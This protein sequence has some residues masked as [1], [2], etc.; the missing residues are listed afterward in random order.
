[1]KVAPILSQMKDLPDIFCPVLVHTGQHYDVQMSDVFFQELGLPEPDHHLGVGSGSHAQQTA[2]VLM[3][4][5]EVLSK[6]EPQVVVVVGDVNPTV[7]CAMDASKANIPVAH[8][9]AGL[10][11][12]DRR[13]P[14][15]I[16]RIVTDA[17]SDFLFTPS[18]DA[19][20]NLRGEGVSQNRIFRVGNVM[21]DSLRKMEPAADRSDVLERLG[22]REKEYALLTLHR[23]SN[24]DDREVLAGILDALDAI[25]REIQVIFTVHPRT[26]ARLEAFELQSRVV[27]M[28]GLTMTEPV[29]YLDSLKLQK[30]ARLVLTDS[31]G[32]QEETT[33]FGVPCLTLRENTER[34]VTIS[35]GTNTLVGVAP[36]AIV[37]AARA[38]L[39]GSVSKG[40]I[41]ELW[42][43]HTAERIVD[44]LQ[45]RLQRSG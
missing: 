12:R 4:F 32:L 8:V 5:E 16:N 21:I 27:A 30:E 17:I 13:M 11:S 19:D 25:Q 44:V 41:P 45:R 36:E 39:E 33:A 40:R 35:E 1:M 20:G 43:G 34:P 31:G 15:E 3:A 18:A 42:D 23:P 6:E 29:S 7:A 22:A 26:R 28:G 2:R 37:G 38:V 24:V 10:R 9:E 14:E